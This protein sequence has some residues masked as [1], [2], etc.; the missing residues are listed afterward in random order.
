MAE[1]K[2]ATEVLKNLEE[3][4]QGKMAEIAEVGKKLQEQSMKLP[5]EIKKIG[6]VKGVKMVADA[7]KELEE[8]AK[9]EKEGI[10]TALKDIQKNMESL[11][12]L[13]EKAKTENITE[14]VKSILAT[15]NEKQKSLKGSIK[16]IEALKDKYTKKFFG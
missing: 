16:D 4:M 7:V 13:K 12:G 10:E 2:V 6:D 5:E 3:E 9:G 15:I 11:K 1:G 14:E 8:E